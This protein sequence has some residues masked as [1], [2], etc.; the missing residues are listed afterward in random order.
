MNQET[1]NAS[2]FFP[3]G[4][5]NRE[6]ACFESGIKL[7]AIFHSIL[8]LPVMN[9]REILKRIQDGLEGAFECQPFVKDVNIK[10]SFPRT[11]KYLK[12]D[13]YDYTLINEQMVEVD[14]DL[15]Y[16][17]IN[18]HAKIKWVP[19]ME[20]PLMYIHEISETGDIS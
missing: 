19:E 18:I 4:I 3:A 7:G 12:T 13:Q 9:K 1:D 5:T 8:R 20:Y 11:G 14:L 6:R 16:N 17:N 2:K 15:E 10:I